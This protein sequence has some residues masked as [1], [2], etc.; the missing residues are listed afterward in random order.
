MSSSGRKWEE[1]VISLIKLIQQR[2]IVTQGYTQVIMMK[3]R[4]VLIRY[5]INLLVCLIKTSKGSGLD[6]K[7]Y[8]IL[9]HLTCIHCKHKMKTCL[10]IF[11]VMNCNFETIVF[12][13]KYSVRWDVVTLEKLYITLR[14]I[15]CKF[16]MMKSVTCGP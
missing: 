5:R 11:L 9:N 10:F 2:Q 4:D 7:G 3:N 16:V 8:R 1:R 6:Y 15:H 12:H 13:G 14:S